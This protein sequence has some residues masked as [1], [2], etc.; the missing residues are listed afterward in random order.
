MSGV[1]KSIGRTFKKVVKVMKKVALPVL[2]IGAVALTGGAALGIIPAL[3]GAGGLLASVGIS[4]ALGSIITTAASGAAFGALGAAVTGGNIIKGATKGLVVGGITG[5]V[6]AALGGVG[7]AA[8]AAPGA[9]PAGGGSVTGF[10]TPAEKLVS[11]G[12]SL[13]STA[14]A[15]IAPGIG[16]IGSSAVQAATA[17]APQV[18]QVASSGGSGGLLG[19]FNGM[20]P[21]TQGSII[22][23]IG[24]AL[25]AGENAKD[26]RRAREARADSYSDNSGLF[27][28]GADANGGSRYDAA[29]YGKVKY[30][31]RTGQVTAI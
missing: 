31:P 23:G 18:A 22:Q 20:N 6:G 21:V 14:P 11:S 10:M 1:L 27:N 29:I 30:D 25:T 4:G 7:G 24:G 26:E 8:A 15:A 5:G 12:T 28:G 3:G 13:A 2:A 9:A 16:G 19:W 17:A